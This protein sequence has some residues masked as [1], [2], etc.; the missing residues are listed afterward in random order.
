MK[1]KIYSSGSKRIY[2]NMKFPQIISLCGLFLIGPFSRVYAEEVQGTLVRRTSGKDLGLPYTE[3]K[4]CPTSKPGAKCVSVFTGPTGR[5]STTL[6]PGRYS[7]TVPYEA[8]RQSYAGQIEVVRGV[9]IYP[10]IVIK[11]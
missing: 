7:V 11:P 9:A 1:R 6:D 8:K 3:L 2:A 5:F 4:I 10:K